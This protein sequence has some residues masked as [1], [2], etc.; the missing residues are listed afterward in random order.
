MSNIRT[1]LGTRSKPGPLRLLLCA[2]LGVIITTA[3]FF[4][5][6]GTA[7]ADP[8]G[9]F[10]G[11]ATGNEQ[12]YNPPECNTPIWAPTFGLDCTEA[13]QAISDDVVKTV[14]AAGSSCLAAA[15][16]AGWPG[17]QA[18]AVGSLATAWTGWWGD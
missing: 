1:A 16:F 5:T 7:K 15:Y 11:P 17:C 4:A 12:V 2:L 13:G 14:G 18:A 6:G 8:P 9:E 3:I 10:V